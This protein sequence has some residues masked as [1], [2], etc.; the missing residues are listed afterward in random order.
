MRKQA[1]AA[2][3]CRPIRE[4]ARAA[5]LA[6]GGHRPGADDYNFAGLHR[7]A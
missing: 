7:D 3:H 2:E 1:S 5:S 6:P 4:A